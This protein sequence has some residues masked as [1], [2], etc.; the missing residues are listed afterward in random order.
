MRAWLAPALALAAAP[1]AAASAQTASAPAPKPGPPPLLIPAPPS[2]DPFARYVKASGKF[3]AEGQTY[4]LE[5]LVDGE[6]AVLR[7][8][9]GQLPSDGLYP[10]TAPSEVL[11]LLA[12]RKVAFLWPAL[13]DWAGPSLERMRAHLLAAT[14]RAFDARRSAKF[15]QGTGESIMRPAARA[16]A[17]Y[18]RT[19]DR[20]GGSDAAVELLRREAGALD[21][22]KGWG[23]TEYSILWVQMAGILHHRGETEAAIAEL[24]TG[25]AAL[26]DSR[27]AANLAITRAAMLVE[28]RRYREGLD[29]V[30]KL[31]A[32]FTRSG[33]S[34]VPG[35]DRQFA[36]IRACALNGL[37][38]A[39]EAQRAMPD[40]RTRPD[41]V[42]PNWIVATNAS[43]RI[44]ALLCMGDVEGLVQEL[45]ADLESGRLMPHALFILQ[46]AVA[47]QHHA[48]PVWEKV[49]ADPRLVAAAR[50]RLRLLPP[51]LAPAL[52]AWRAAP[53][54]TTAP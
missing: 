13:L 20:T 25:L 41:P 19:L 23:R 43:I 49:R 31:W 10:I 5:L 9:G 16:V 38:R 15:P 40:L 28:S 26:G 21:L 35:S 2:A 36:W 12:D 53:G 42:D 46:P 3:D 37:G 29:A 18:A 51:E 27:Y 14:E 54:S 1:V 8:R 33:G 22:K 44:R 48:Q 7:T 39:A 30:D 52:R 47:L 4:V 32:T 45:L 11:Y 50:D 34:K 17:Q 6:N 24:S